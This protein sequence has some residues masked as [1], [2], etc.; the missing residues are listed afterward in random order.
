MESYWAHAKTIGNPS[1]G[2]FDLN[3]PKAEMT[4]LV[5]LFDSGIPR[6]VYF[7]IFAHLKGL[8]SE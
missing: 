6:E 7:F 5:A 1:K 4:P 2:V 3:P 8:A